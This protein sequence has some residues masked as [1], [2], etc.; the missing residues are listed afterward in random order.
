LDADTFKPLLNGKDLAKALNT[1]PGPWMKDALDIVMAWQL[2]NASTTDPAEA[3]EAVKHA[4]QSDSEL[5]SRL[6]SHFLQ[7]TIPPL[8]A[9]NKPASAYEAA[10][11]PAPWTD[12]ANAYVLDLLEWSIGA[13][14]G[15]AVETNWHLLV[16]PVLKMIDGA[17]VPCKA[18][19]CHMLNL[20]LESLAHESTSSNSSSPSFLDRT[21][22]TH[23]FTS[24]LCPLFTYLPSLTPESDSATLLA[25]AHEPLTTLALAQREPADRT[26]ALDTLLRTGVLDPLAYLPT[27]WTYPHLSATLVQ[28]MSM[29]IGHLGWATVKHVPRV[30][31]VLRAIVSEPFALAHEQ[32]TVAALHAM[33][34]VLRTTW[35]RVPANRAGFVMGLCVLWGRCVDGARETIGREEEGVVERVKGEVQETVAMLDALLCASVDGCEWAA[36]KALVVEAGQGFA[37]LFDTCDGDITRGTMK[38]EAKEEEEGEGKKQTDP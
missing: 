22:Y 19:G 13:L 15:K 23:V 25:A 21:G 16:P 27:P 34:A 32:L 8:F 26:A 31:P 6:A 30:L 12:A 24:S 2:R 9:Q 17:D 35:M 29:L 37:G 36:E 10:A 28:N 14:R 33:R 20:L 7:L 18:R 38:V 5:P 11:Q 4:R 1:K 3:I